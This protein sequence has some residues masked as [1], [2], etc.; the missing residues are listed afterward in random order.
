LLNAEA[1][2]DT[3]RLRRPAQRSPEMLIIII[4]IIIMVDAMAA[5]GTSK[6]TLVSM[7]RRSGQARVEHAEAGRLAA[8]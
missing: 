5:T 6:W 3:R 7:Q 4:I 1:R 8:V 2:R